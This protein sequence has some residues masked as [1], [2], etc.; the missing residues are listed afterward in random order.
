[1]GSLVKGGLEEL[2][3]GGSAVDPNRP[4]ISKEGD[5]FRGAIAEEGGRITNAEKFVA[6]PAR[7][8]GTLSAALSPLKGLGSTTKAGRVV[9]AIG[10]A[11]ELI[12]P[13]V[14]AGKGTSL[15]AKGAAK[16]VPVVT[17]G[18]AEALGLTTGQGSP[19]ARA[20]LDIGA[21]SS[22]ARRKLGSA[23][24]LPS[25]EALSPEDFPFE[26]QDIRAAR[27]DE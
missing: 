3:P 18:I 17:K 27:Q 13:L 10:R 6:D 7:A 21:S 20:L 1:M 2:R 25:G 15:L 22:A 19:A 16:S 5:L 23:D 26:S 9:G 11:G 14:A 24:D 8:L 4:T 12:D